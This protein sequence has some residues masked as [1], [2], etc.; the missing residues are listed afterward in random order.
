MHEIV[1]DEEDVLLV[2][3][4]TESY[5]WT[6]R[7]RIYEAVSCGRHPGRNGWITVKM[8]VESVTLR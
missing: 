7:L 2:G 6:L 8:H 1:V 5:D 4:D 3:N